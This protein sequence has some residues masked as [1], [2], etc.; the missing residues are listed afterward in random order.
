MTT[1]QWQQ[2]LEGDVNDWIINEISTAN[3]ETNLR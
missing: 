3:I 1:D 2:G